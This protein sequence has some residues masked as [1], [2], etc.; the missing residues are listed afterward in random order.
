VEFLVGIGARK[1]DQPRV[2][3]HIVDKCC[4]SFSGRNLLG[5][6]CVKSGN[7]TRGERR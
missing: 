4:A 3:L 5:T 6:D 2:A 1:F 7:S